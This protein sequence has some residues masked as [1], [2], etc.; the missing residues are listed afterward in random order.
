MQTVSAVGIGVVI[1][2]IFSEVLTDTFAPEVQSCSGTAHCL[3]R[4]YDKS[5]LTA[6]FE[7]NRNS[8]KINPAPSTA[9]RT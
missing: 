8:S 9:E 3:A 5:C 7:I 6:H 2:V 1:G 4:A